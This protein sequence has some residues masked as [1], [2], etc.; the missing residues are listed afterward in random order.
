MNHY[1]I[2]WKGSARYFL[3]WFCLKK[4]WKLWNCGT[5]LTSFC[6]YE[7][8]CNCLL[9]VGSF[10]VI[11]G[12]EI[13]QIKY[14][15]ILSMSDK[16]RRVIVWQAIQI[17]PGFLSNTHKGAMYITCDNMIFPWFF[18]SV[19]VGFA[20]KR[21]IKVTVFDVHDFFWYVYAHLLCFFWS[22]FEP[23]LES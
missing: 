1:S 3:W 4:S 21:I 17:W 20:I 7:N 12:N 5:I 2:K 19:F 16:Y 15:T 8:V 14:L 6:C 9:V 13:C 10:T 22:T 23:K 18:M 11:F